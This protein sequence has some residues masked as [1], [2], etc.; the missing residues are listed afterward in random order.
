MKGKLKKIASSVM[1][2]IPYRTATAYSKELYGKYVGI[3][4]ILASEGAMYL[5]C[6]FEFT[7]DEKGITLTRPIGFEGKTLDFQVQYSPE[8]LTSPV[9]GWGF[10]EGL[11]VRQNVDSQLA[12]MIFCFAPRF[13]LCKH[14]VLIFLGEGTLAVL[15]V[16]VKASRE[17]DLMVMYQKFH[18]RLGPAKTPTGFESLISVGVN[19]AFLVMETGTVE[20]K[21]DILENLA[22]NLW[23]AP[24][25]IVSERLAV[26]KLG[27]H[28][29]NPS[30]Q[31]RALETFILGGR[32][33]GGVEIVCDMLFEIEELTPPVFAVVVDA[34][35]CLLYEIYGHLLPYE[36]A[37]KMFGTTNL[38]EIFKCSPVVT[39]DEMELI[40]KIADTCSIT[41]EWTLEHY[42]VLRQ[43]LKFVLEMHGDDA[44]FIPDKTYSTITET[45][46][47]YPIIE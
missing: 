19:E 46:K 44:H 3:N 18:K 42:V 2:G 28:D 11:A 16:C 30:V 40:D 45:L 12:S 38:A 33:T 32:V 4:P 7:F 41:R 21:I 36:N 35:S 43:A 8:W 15:G 22:H 25:E 13:S 37:K 47:K 10:D 34:A 31:I 20:E 23:T 17:L 6:R 27:C 26:I 1:T 14:D 9:K 5:D 29:K 39:P 24:T